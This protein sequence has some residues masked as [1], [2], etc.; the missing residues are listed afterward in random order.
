V[1]N[2]GW[3]HGKAEAKTLCCFSLNEKRRMFPSFKCLLLGQMG[4]RVLVL[5]HILISTAKAFAN[6]AMIKPN[7][8]Q[9]GRH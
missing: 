1:P 9:K 4:R 7:P 3:F 8:L 2:G 5:P 6:G